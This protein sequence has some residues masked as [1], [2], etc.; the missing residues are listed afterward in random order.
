VTSPQAYAGSTWDIESS[1]SIIV[2]YQGLLTGPA[3]FSTTLP[4]SPQGSSGSYV[5]TPVSQQVTADGR[6]VTLTAHNTTW[7]CH[8][9]ALT[10]DVSPAG[11]FQ[12]A[13]KG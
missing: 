5:A 4:S 13:R 10:L 7:T 11:T 6:A 9:S 8:G 3:T 12:L 2:N 1:G